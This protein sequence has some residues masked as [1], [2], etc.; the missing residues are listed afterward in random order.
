MRKFYPFAGRIVLIEKKKAKF[1]HSP[2]HHY[3][4]IYGALFFSV[5]PVRCTCIIKYGAVRKF[6]QEKCQLGETA[7]LALNY[8]CLNHK[9]CVSDDEENCFWDL[10]GG[11]LKIGEES[12]WKDISQICGNSS[13][14][15]CIIKHHM[16]S[17]VKVWSAKVGVNPEKYLKIMLY[18]NK[19]TA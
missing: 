2:I 1:P 7:R 8:Q 9:K 16:T 10:K 15:T 13:Y 3:T 12:N 5:S 14:F 18:K 4:S 11:R 17:K 6:F 19:V